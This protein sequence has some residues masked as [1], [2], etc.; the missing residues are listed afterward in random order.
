MYDMIGLT[1]TVKS[2][3]YSRKLIIFRWKSIRTMV[4]FQLY[5]PPTI[6]VKN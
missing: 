4:L 2:K 5:T 6:T 1:T 3:L